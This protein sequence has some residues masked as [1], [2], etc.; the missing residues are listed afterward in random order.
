MNLYVLMRVVIDVAEREIRSTSHGHMYIEILAN[1]TGPRYD[2]ILIGLN[3]S[4]HKQQ[5]VG[6]IAVLGGNV[7]PLAIILGHILWKNSVRL[8]KSSLADSEQQH[9]AFAAMST[10]SV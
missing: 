9:G 3:Q 8:H 1:A 10:Y 7:R 6:W 2:P 4:A 5:A